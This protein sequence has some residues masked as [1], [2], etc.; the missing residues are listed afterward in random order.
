MNKYIDPKWWG[1]NVKEGDFVKLLYQPSTDGKPYFP[2]RTKVF[3]FKRLSYVL[4]SEHYYIISS[5]QDWEIPLFWV[6]EVVEI[7]HK[8]AQ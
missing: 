6:T 7:R 3:E 1:E 5:E 2:V 4:K 8:E